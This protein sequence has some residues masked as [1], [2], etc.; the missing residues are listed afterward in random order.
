MISRIKFLGQYGQLGSC[1]N[2]AHHLSNTS[3]V[4]ALFIASIYMCQEAWGL[5]PKIF[6]IYFRLN[7]S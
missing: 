5:L 1:H 4:I 7:L 6:S 3:K 2:F